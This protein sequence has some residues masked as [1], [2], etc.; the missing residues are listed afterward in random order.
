VLIGASVAAPD[1]SLVQKVLLFSGFVAWQVGYTAVH[2][3]RPW[4]GTA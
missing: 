2:R 4:A 3:L 1:E